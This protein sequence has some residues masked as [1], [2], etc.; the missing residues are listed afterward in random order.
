VTPEDIRAWRD[1]RGLSQQDLAEALGVRQATVSR[2]ETGERPATMPLVAL[3]LKALG[4]K[5]RRKHAS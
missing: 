4:S 1:A 5:I 2:W 3:A